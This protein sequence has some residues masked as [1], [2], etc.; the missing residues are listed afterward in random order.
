MANLFCMHIMWYESEMI[1]ETLNSI[2]AALML[3]QEPVD[4]VFCLNS[5]T[6]LEEPIEGAADEMFAAFT[7]HPLLSNAR[8]YQKTME[9]EFY[10]IGDF[11]REN[12]SD[13]GLT[14][15]GE[16]DCLVPKEYFRVCESFDKTQT[17]PYV[18]SYASRKMWDSTWDVVVYEPHRKLAL[19][20][21]TPT[22]RYDSVITQRFL[23]DFN[24]VSRMHHGLKIEPVFPSK[25]DG[26]LLCI[27][28]G[29]PQL[30]P[31]N[32]HFAR[33]DFCAQLTL[34]TAGI[35]QYVVKTQIKGHNYAHPKKR[36]NTLN[37]RHDQQYRDKEKESMDV[38][39]EWLKT[40]AS[41]I[42]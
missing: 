18:L 11:R 20:T 27:S 13:D 31:D 42:Q 39:N 37:T 33:E 24:H 17:T 10:N 19:E 38:L 1:N 32:L 9:D 7:D 40:V 30:I 41:G 21:M 26:S 8:I 35:T 22:W 28:K 36:L 15:W 14:Y 12:R 6:Y 23:D 3:A 29:V 34:D 2:Q 25:I 5:Q 16:S 4:L